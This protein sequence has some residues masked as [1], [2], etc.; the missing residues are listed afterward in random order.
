MRRLILAILLLP[1]VLFAQENKPPVA[2]IERL[3]WLAGNWRQE[4]AGRLTDEQWMAPAG[5]VM[6]GM[7]RTVAKGKV[8]EHEFL[9]LRA[10]PGG[11]LFYIAMP[12]RQK[13]AAFQAASAS[14]RVCRGR[15]SRK[16]PDSVITTSMRGLPSSASGIRSAPDSR[17]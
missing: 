13:E 12:S 10:G 3:A 9:Q 17:P 2:T 16:M 8:L 7:S 6:L 14:I 5:G 1:S 4:K 15:R 11:E